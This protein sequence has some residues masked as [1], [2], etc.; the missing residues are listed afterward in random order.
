MTNKFDDLFAART[1][2]KKSHA[3]QTDKLGKPYIDH[4]TDVAQRVSHLGAEIETVAWLHD[5]VEDTEVTIK[6]LSSKF[7][8][9]VSTAVDAMTRRAGE[10][11]LSQYLPRLLL[12]QVALQVKLA[13]LQH[14]QE[15]LPQLAVID[16]DTAIRLEGKYSKA[17]TMLLNDQCL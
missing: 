11:Y 15:K 13:D 6:E 2:A 3:G 5:I 17:A 10:D 12:N 9:K 4:V 14:N 7:S 16:P 1:L 8:C